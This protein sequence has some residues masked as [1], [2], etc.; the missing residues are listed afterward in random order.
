MKSIITA[1]ALLVTSW[2]TFALE[3]LCGMSLKTFMEGRLEQGV[4]ANGQWLIRWNEFD[5]IGHFSIG[6][7][8]EQKLVWERSYCALG[9]KRISL[10]TIGTRLQSINTSADQNAAAVSAWLQYVTIPL[11][12]PSLL[13][14]RQDVQA[15]S[16]PK[17]KPFT[18]E[19]CK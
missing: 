9:A 19:F 4:P 15:Q 13:K 1:L 14:V 2:P 10:A 5:D 11:S 8:G 6:A 16:C 3:P 18:P 7:N 12:D 17:L